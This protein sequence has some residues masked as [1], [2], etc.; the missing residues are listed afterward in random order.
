MNRQSSGHS[1]IK[2]STLFWNEKLKK[3]ILQASILLF[4]REQRQWS[5]ILNIRRH[6]VYIVLQLRFYWGFFYFILFLSSLVVCVLLFWNV[7]EALTQTVPAGPLSRW[8]WRSLNLWSNSRF[9]HQWVLFFFFT[10][11]VKTAPVGI[12]KYLTELQ[13]H[14]WCFQCVSMWSELGATL[15]TLATLSWR[16]FGRCAVRRKSKL[17]SQLF[18]SGLCVC[19]NTVKPWSI[20]HWLLNGGMRTWRTWTLKHWRAPGGSSSVGGCKFALLASYLHIWTE[21]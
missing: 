13:A 20:R 14:I 4:R 1:T 15:V 16:C 8:V 2:S 19:M 21:F 17:F 12:L 5:W 11:Q 18:Y 10:I 6:C 3:T 9:Y 7:I